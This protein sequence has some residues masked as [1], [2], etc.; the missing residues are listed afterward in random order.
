MDFALQDEGQQY[1]NLDA[2]FSI[3]RMP[4]KCSV[5]RRSPANGLYTTCHQLST[6]V[7]KTKRAE[8]SKS[9]RHLPISN[10][11]ALRDGSKSSIEGQQTKAFLIFQFLLELVHIG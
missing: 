3:A 1:G 6:S 5:A 10:L 9:V 7:L 2:A 8:Q 11:D 4:R